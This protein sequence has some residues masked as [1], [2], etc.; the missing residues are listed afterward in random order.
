MEESMN[1]ENRDQFDD[2]L[3]D[4]YPEENSYQESIGLDLG[5]RRRILGLNNSISIEREARR[6]RRSHNSSYP[7]SVSYRSRHFSGRSTGTD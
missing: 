4:L 6:R 2:H 5:E 3:R 7:H 1:Y